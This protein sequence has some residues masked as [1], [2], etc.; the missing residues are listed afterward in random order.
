ML[1]P[2]L[3]SS[4]H[5]E[6]LRWIA[7][8]NSVFCQV[9]DEA[10]LRKKCMVNIHQW[11][12]ALGRR[13]WPEQHRQQ[14]VPWRLRRSRSWWPPSPPS[15]RRSWS[16]PWRAG[17]ERVASLERSSGKWGV[18]HRPQISPDTRSYLSSWRQ[19]QWWMKQTD[20]RFKW[21]KAG[22]WWAGAEVGKSVKDM[23]KF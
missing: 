1:R 5:F 8:V 7:E 2:E 10:G 20:Q 3:E 23:K 17:E 15:S 9:Q 18:C 11:T 4:L 22:D 12:P 6:M 19:W 13:P 21:T 16:S 14:E